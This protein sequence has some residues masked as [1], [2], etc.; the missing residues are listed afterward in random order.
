MLPHGLLVRNHQQ[1]PILHPING[2]SQLATGKGHALERVGITDLTRFG[3]MNPIDP[4]LVLDLELV[5]E[6]K[7]EIC[8]GHG[9]A[10]KEV[11]CHPTF[12]VTI[13]RCL[14]RE[15]VHE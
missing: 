6:V 10:C 3:V 14:V 4:P 1:Q 5:L 13:W 8:R 11:S 2:T 15:M 12:L 9:S 7:Q